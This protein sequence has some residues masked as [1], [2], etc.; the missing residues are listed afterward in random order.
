MG[1][2]LMYSLPW[3]LAGALILTVSGLTSPMQPVVAQDVTSQP[4]QASTA[5]A[6]PTGSVQTTATLA[7]ATTPS[8]TRTPT[9]TP[10]PTPTFTAWQVQLALAQAYLHGGAYEKAAD[11]FAAL[12]LENRGNSEALAGLDA[13]LKGQVAATA[14][15]MAP[16]PTPAAPATPTPS[17]PSLAGIFT[18]KWAVFAGMASAALAAVLLVYLLARGLR[19]VFFS[20]RELWFVRVRRPPVC[21]SLLIGPFVSATGDEAFRGPEIVV[22]ALTEQLISWNGAVQEELRVPVTIDRLESAGM[23]WLSVLWQWILPAPRAYK[24]T[25]VLLGNR[26]GP[27]ALSVDRLDMRN[28]RVDASHTFEGNADTPGQA[29]RQMAMTAAFWVRDPV[30][31]EAS[32]G[33]MEVPVRVAGLSGIAGAAATPTPTQ[34]AGEVLKLMG[35]VRQQAN[36]GTVDYSVSPRALNEVQALLDRLPPG[37][38]LRQDLQSALDDL[39]RTVQPGATPT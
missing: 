12:A 13:A 17:R 1:R 32:P 24:V 5:G 21:P 8:A 20:L 35:T 2:R 11:I 31:L 16:L 34:L 15:A 22:Q 39:R 3:L 23:A 18:V 30:G 36:R 27:Y 9:L 26:P 33:M 4:V 14:T 7:A 19:W 10:T 37:S 38:D 29:F 28:N 6:L 25:G